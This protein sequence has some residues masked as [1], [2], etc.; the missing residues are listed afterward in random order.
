MN[1]ST[2]GAELFYSTQGRG[3]VVLLPSAMGARPYELQ[4]P[5]PLT[6]HFRFAYVELRGSGRSTGT[7]ADLTY[8]VLAED[9]EAVRKHLGAERVAVLGHSILGALAVEYA[10]RCPES[11]SHVILAGTPPFGDM[12]RVVDAA[13][14]YFCEA[15][16]EERT[17]LQ[18]ASLAK[19]TPASPPG[20]VL[21]AQT[22]SRFYDPRF[23][24]APLYAEADGRSTLIPHLLGTLTPAW[25]I[26][27]DPRPLRPPLLIAHGRH[28]YVVPWTLWNGVKERLPDATLQLFE[29]SGHQP[30]FEEPARFA[31]V[32]L[33]WMRRR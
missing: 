8:D 15:A 4:T 21:M 30:F 22:P 17:R 16:G 24:P 11:V 5:P 23:N 9:L 13:K 25:D 33:E 28:D 2:R 10:R 1:V 26:T 32:V 6:D 3:P 14:A 20:E 27:A 7:P 31:E 12:A 19:L 29:K 18:Q